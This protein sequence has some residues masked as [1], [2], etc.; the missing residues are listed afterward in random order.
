MQ[1]STFVRDLDL[2]FD[3]MFMQM[4]TT[5]SVD[6][7]QDTETTDTTLEDIYYSQGMDPSSTMPNIFG[8]RSCT[9]EIV[10][11]EVYYEAYFPSL[12]LDTLAQEQAFKQGYVSTVSQALSVPEESV[13]I[14]ALIKGSVRVESKISFTEVT[15]AKEFKTVV[16]PHPESTST[17]F[18]QGF[19][20]MYGTPELAVTVNP[21]SSPPSSHKDAHAPPEI[22]LPPTPSDIDN[23][24]G[25]QRES[26][27][28]ISMFVVALVLRCT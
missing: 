23:G 19:K 5:N 3:S 4:V 14:L 13:I 21:L 26:Q 12:Q 25:A 20:Q 6:G 9:A 18:A 28:L 1:P 27:I 22:L 17:L 11:K 15:S 2:D 7:S 8:V 24:V 16:I 10:D